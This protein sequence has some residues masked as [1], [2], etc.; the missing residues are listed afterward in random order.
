MLSG[1]QESTFDSIEGSLKG[2]VLLLLIAVE[3]I[4]KAA[5]WAN[6]ESVPK[7]DFGIH[8][9]QV[10]GTLVDLGGT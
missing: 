10:G 8:P 6:R 4:F 3:E 7:S 9:S 5:N 2:L 1:L